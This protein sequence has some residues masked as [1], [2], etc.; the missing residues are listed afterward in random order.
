[1][2]I[3]AALKTFTPG[4]DWIH[5]AFG[6]LPSVPYNTSGLVMTSRSSSGFM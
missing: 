6:Y 3:A 2:P 5:P 4:Q 1:M